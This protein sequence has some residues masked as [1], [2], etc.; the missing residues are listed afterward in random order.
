M[1]GYARFLE[2]ELQYDN[3]DEIQAETAPKIDTLR[4]FNKTFRYAIHVKHLKH[5]KKEQIDEQTTYR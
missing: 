3:L 2:P 4:I 1:T 5:R